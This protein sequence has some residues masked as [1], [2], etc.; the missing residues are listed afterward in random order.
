MRVLRH[1][2]FQLNVDFF[3]GAAEPERLLHS[4]LLFSLEH[5][6]CYVVNNA[7]RTK[8]QSL[9]TINVYNFAA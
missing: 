3:Y 9:C 2:V 7:E 8:W 6:F 1:F 5:A 4:A